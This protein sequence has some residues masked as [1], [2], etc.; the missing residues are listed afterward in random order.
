MDW[1]A[2]CAPR[3]LK[4]GDEGNVVRYT[5]GGMRREV[6][7]DRR[8]NGPPASANG[9]YACGVVAEGVQGV[10]TVMLR[11]PP[12]LDSPMTLKGDG[13]SSTL[14]WGYVLVGEA[15]TDILELDIPEAPGFDAAEEAV[16]RYVGF[17]AHQFDTCFVCGPKRLPGDGL[18][19]FPGSIDG[20]NVVASPWTPDASL[21]LEG[22]EIDRRHVWAALD[23]PSYFGIVPSPPAVLGRLTAQIDRL[24]ELG[25]PLIAM[26]WPVRS[27][28]RK[29]HSG[30]ALATTDGEIIASAKAVW[31]EPK[32]GVPG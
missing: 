1:R 28:G 15:S 25:E 31:I 19:I 26:G 17:Q 8:F 5:I 30:S 11:M 7:I 23:C 29:H 3:V 16:A 9:G 20:S 22:G 14:M 2:I 27:E 32:S 10:A 6:L 12:P 4:W 13:E 21:S 24:P 18:C